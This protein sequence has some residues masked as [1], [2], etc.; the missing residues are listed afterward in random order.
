MLQVA[1]SGGVDGHCVGGDCLHTPSP[2][3]A[4][5]LSLSHILKPP[6]PFPVPSIPTSHPPL[7][8]PCH[9]CISCRPPHS[10]PTFPEGHPAWPLPHGLP[11]D[12]LRSSTH[13]KLWPVSS[14]K[15]RAPVPRT[16]F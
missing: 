5:S 16:H 9:T 14:P 11:L 2:Q 3:F 6:H 8:I 1:S 15:G 13:P 4:P 12:Y 7:P 10:I